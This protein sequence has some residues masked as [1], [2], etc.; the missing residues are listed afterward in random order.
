[1]GIATESDVRPIVAIEA[2]EGLVFERSWS[3]SSDLTT[4]MMSH[5]RLQ[6]HCRESSERRS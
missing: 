2:C 5:D 4:A 1:M 3:S 6:V